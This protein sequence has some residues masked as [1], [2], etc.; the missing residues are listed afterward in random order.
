MTT[1]TFASKSTTQPFPAAAKHVAGHM[2]RKAGEPERDSEP[3]SVGRAHYDDQAADVLRGLA[4]L[5]YTVVKTRV[6]ART[7]RSK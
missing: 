4:E 5:G 6:T 7:V 1:G 3:T 2:W